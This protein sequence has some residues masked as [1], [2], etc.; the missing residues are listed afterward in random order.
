MTVKQLMDKLRT[1]PEDMPV[2]TWN[3][4]NHHDKDDPDHIE[5]TLCTWVDGNYPYSQPDFEYVNLL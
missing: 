1:Y 2:A 4:I 5:V 3:D